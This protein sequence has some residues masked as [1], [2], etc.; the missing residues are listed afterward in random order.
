[1]L[2]AKTMLEEA[3]RRLC[4]HSSPDCMKVADLGCSVGPNTLLVMSNIIDI[5]HAVCVCLNREPP[6]FQFYLNDLF[7]N[8]FNTIFKSL[9]D[10]LLEGLIEEEKLDSFNIPL[11]EATVEEIRDVIGEEG[12]FFIQESE[13]AMVPWDARKIEDGDDILVDEKIGAEFITRY[14]RAAMEP[15]LAAN[16]GT[17]IMNELF[18]RTSPA[19][20]VPIVNHRAVETLEADTPFA[21]VLCS[22]QLRI[23][24]VAATTTARDLHSDQSVAGRP[25][26]TP[27]SNHP[28]PTIANPAA[29]SGNREPLSHTSLGLRHR[30]TTS[31]NEIAA[32]SEVARRRRC[33]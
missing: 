23:T 15:L 28:R 2:K 27:S 30:T 25:L 17:E 32:V 7:G 20:T 24:G 26:L 33:R 16:F 8:D 21:H 29:V 5:V 11:Y 6:T 19:N 13:I 12:S 18:I 31:S 4:C 10:M 14:I 3:I 1:M 22:D 9:P